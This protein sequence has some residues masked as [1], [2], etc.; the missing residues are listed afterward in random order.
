MTVRSKTQLD[1]DKAQ[2]LCDAATPGPWHTFGPPWFRD[3]L[4]VLAGSPDPHTAR[5]VAD[6]SPM[7]ALGDDAAHWAQNPADAEFIATARTLV[8]K[9]VAELRAY[10]KAIEALRSWQPESH[11]RQTLLACL[12]EALRQG[13]AS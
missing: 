4:G 1:L 2:R 6:L 12:D 3:E 7:E 8:P 11:S 9:L 13:G 5:F 10:H